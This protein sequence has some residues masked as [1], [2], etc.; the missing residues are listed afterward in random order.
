MVRNLRHRVFSGFLL[1]GLAVFM[2]GP[3]L[4]DHSNDAGSPPKK[5]D[6][7]T[8][9]WTD[10]TTN[11]PAA[12]T[13]YTVTDTT[14][15][16]FTVSVQKLG[17]GPAW[18]LTFDINWNVKQDNLWNSNPGDGLGFQL[19]LKVG[20]SWIVSGTN[21]NLQ[22]GVVFRHKGNSKVVSEEKVQTS[23]GE[24]EAF[25]VVSD[26]KWLAINGGGLKSEIHAETWYAPQINRIIKRRVISR[27][28][29]H[30]QSSYSSE[31]TDNSPN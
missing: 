17:S 25:K 6:Q 10:L 9:D 5:G 16:D 20:K 31:L 8:Y 7:W 27:L 30:V 23:A 15:T 1:A 21:K 2:S 28:G 13:T 24:F 14:E 19:P 11:A 26:L 18:L 12:T 3:S 22:N 4:A 29:G